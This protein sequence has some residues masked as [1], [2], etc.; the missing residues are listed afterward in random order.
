VLEKTLFNG[1][2]S[3]IS[4]DGTAFFYVNPLEALSEASLKDRRMRH[5]KIKRHKWFACAC[6]PPNIARMIACLGNYVHSVN[7]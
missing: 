7:K 6:C 3:G 2:I 4:L 1:I 5:V